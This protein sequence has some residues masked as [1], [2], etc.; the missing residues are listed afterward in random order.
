MVSFHIP[1]QSEF[2]VA[3]RG[4]HTNVHPASA[5]AG[6]VR[7]VIPTEMPTAFIYCNDPTR[8]P[9]TSLPP[10]PFWLTDLIVADS[11]AVGR[12]LRSRDE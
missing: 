1:P 7:G 10:L 2:P 5:S 8:M 4:L 3:D 11:V 9:T 12:Y 6:T